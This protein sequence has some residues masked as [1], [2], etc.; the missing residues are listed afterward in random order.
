MNE[1]LLTWA[2]YAGI[3][4]CV[5]ALAYI[6]PFTS[7]PTELLIKGLGFILMK[8]LEHKI[9]FLI[10]FFKT[11]S[12]DHARVLQHASQT[13]EDIDPTQKIRRQAKGYAD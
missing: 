1:L 12:A 7:G 4:L 3:A 8:L 13:E 9:S 10:W 5:L 2:G 6:I 11:I